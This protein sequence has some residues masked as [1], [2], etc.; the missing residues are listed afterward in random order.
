[1]FLE[2]W[3]CSVPSKLAM[4]LRDIINSHIV[5]SC[6]IINNV[7]IMSKQVGLAEQRKIELEKK[8]N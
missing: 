5:I 7:Q 2:F 3:I 8:R 6:F 4:T 1:M